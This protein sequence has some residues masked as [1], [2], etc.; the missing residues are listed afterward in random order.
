[1]NLVD[2]VRR[3][4]PLTAAHWARLKA[5]DNHDFSGVRRKVREDAKKL[6][7]TIDDEEL[8]AGI[9]ALKQYYAIALLDGLNMHAVS[10]RVDPY[11]HAHILHTQDYVDFCDTVVGCYMHHNPLDHGR[12]ND[13]AFVKDL[14]HF[15]LARYNQCFLHVDQ[16]FHPAAP[17]DDEIVCTH[18][19][20]I[21]PIGPLALFAKE[22]SAQAPAGWSA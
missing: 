14:Y 11:W 3:D 12:K 10:D 19:G 15:T 4:L 8:D 17:S 13:V 16:R 20:D 21:Y 6:G 2:V 1:M 18:A 7:K 22:V 9:L 5:I